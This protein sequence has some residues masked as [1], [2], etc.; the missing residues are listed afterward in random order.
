MRT[1][2]QVP[3]TRVDFGRPARFDGPMIAF[4]SR[5]A[6]NGH[7]LVAGGSGA[8]KTHQL[9]RVIDDLVASGARRVILLDVHGDIHP[10]SPTQTVKFSEQTEFG[11]NPL[12]I[13]A[14]PDF[15]GVRKRIG[16]FVGMINRTGT[17]LGTKQESTLRALL[18][19]MYAWRGFY[20][21]DVRS[22]DVAHDPRRSARYPK[23]MPTLSDLVRFAQ[24]KLRTMRLGGISRSTQA[25][26]QLSR[27]VQA[28][29][30]AGIRGMKGEDVAKQ[31]ARLKADCI[32]TYTE[33]IE[34]LETG[35]ELE[36]VLK[37]DSADTVK[38]V[39]D[40]LETLEGAGI[41]RGR[42]PP[43]ERDH[44]VWRYDIQALSRAEMQQFVEVYLE[45]L[46]FQSKQAGETDGPETFVIIDEASIFV[47]EEPDHILNILFREARKY[48]VAL[49]LANQHLLDFSDDM[50]MSAAVKLILGVDEM[51]HEAMRRRLGMEPV[52][53]RDRRKVNPFAFIRLQ[54]T[55]LVQVKNRGGE[56]IGRMCEIRIIG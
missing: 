41:F 48:G 3:P 46:F 17:K 56:G 44:V 16:A 9:R 27:K 32:E 40:R 52:E 42:T 6:V 14:D 10:D 38:S 50:L 37:Y 11:L 28:L 53:L 30:S 20:V 47:S 55:A 26:E 18:T 2:R 7:M 19:D 54:E 4:D 1:V 31:L 36:D 25:F 39:L 51:F 13:S 5:S 21:D 33:A 35:R 43:F 8:G 22:W 29:Q 15:G 12:A 24:A 45:E 23:S 34:S 49:I